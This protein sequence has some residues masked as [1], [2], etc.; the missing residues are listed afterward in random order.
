MP[1]PEIMSGIF[2]TQKAAIYRIAGAYQK[3]LPPSDSSVRASLQAGNCVDASGLV[4]Y[5][6]HREM[7]NGRTPGNA[8]EILWIAREPNGVATLFCFRA[9]P[10]IDA[11]YQP[12]AKFVEPLKVRMDLG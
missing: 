3:G 2:C 11:S 5:P 9:L 7:V 4:G 8:M 10:G 1:T 12:K 6:V